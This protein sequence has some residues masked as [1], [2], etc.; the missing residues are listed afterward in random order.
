MPRLQR[1]ADARKIRERATQEGVLAERALRKLLQARKGTSRR[2]SRQGDGSKDDAIFK[3]AMVALLKEDYE[4]GRESLQE[5]DELLFL[6]ESEKQTKKEAEERRKQ[7]RA[8]AENEDFSFGPVV[9]HDRA[10]WR[11]GA[12]GLFS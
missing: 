1:E 4:R 8:E 7:E 3:E 6:D 11:S 5:E 2:G 10:H 12:R 9:N